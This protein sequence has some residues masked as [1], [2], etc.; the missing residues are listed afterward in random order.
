[1]PSA[2]RPCEPFLV[3]HQL[4]LHLEGDRAAEAEQAEPKEIPHQIA[5]RYAPGCAFAFHR[6]ILPTGD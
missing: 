6:K 3:A 2:S 1:M 4:A 5:K